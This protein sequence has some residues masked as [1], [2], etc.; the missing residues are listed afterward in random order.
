M[1][2]FEQYLSSDVKPTL[3]KEQ[4]QTMAKRAA[5]KYVNDKVALNDS[6]KEFQKESSLN[7]EQVKR[8]VEMANTAT[9]LH[10]FKLGYDKNVHFDVADANDL[11]SYEPVEKVAHAPVFSP[12]TDYVPGQ[13]YVSL[14][15]VFA[16]EGQVKEADEFWTSAKT[17]EYLSIVDKVKTAASEL[18][19]LEYQFNLQVDKVK[20]AMCEAVN[21]DGA[22]V[23]EA[24]TLIKSAGVSKDTLELIAEDVSNYLKYE[25]VPA[26]ELSPNTEHP[27]YKAAEDLAN[28]HG[29]F[30]GTIDMAKATI[31][32]TEPTD[33]PGLSSIIK[34]NLGKYIQV[35]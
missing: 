16:T 28:L 12:N 8:V 33:Y 3:D 31:T 25:T 15:E 29:R 17:R 9:F 1:S 13:E 19:T 23:S 5:A 26:V 22:S 2:D 30:F 21:D 20:R 14:D 35:D 6:I 34:E 7:D 27:L 32:S 24:V 4:L 11:L 18:E 10:L